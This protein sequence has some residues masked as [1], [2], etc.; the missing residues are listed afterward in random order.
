MLY[1][2]EDN[3]DYDA[4]LEPIVEKQVSDM[5]YRR[6]I[7]VAEPKHWT[8]TAASPRRLT[9]WLS[10]GSHDL[11]SKPL[12]DVLLEVMPEGIDFYPITVVQKGKEHPY[13]DMNVLTIA[14]VVD[15]DRSGIERLS[16]GHPIR[17]QSLHLKP[18]PESATPIFVANGDTLPFGLLCVTEPAA[19]NIAA[20]GFLDIAF[21]P[22]PVGQNIPERVL[23]TSKAINPFSDT[24][25]Q[26]PPQREISWPDPEIFTSPSLRLGPEMTDVQV[27]AIH[28]A[29]G[30]QLPDYYIQFLRNYPAILDTTPSDHRGKTPLSARDVPKDAGQLI[31]MNANVR[32]PGS[33][34]LEDEDGDL[35]WP[36]N[37]WVIGDASSD[38]YCI[39]TNSTEQ[40]V[41]VSD[42]E[43]A[44][45]VPWAASLEEFVSRLVE[46]ITAILEQVREERKSSAAF[47][48]SLRNSLD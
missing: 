28:E 2:L 3:A 27:Q 14:D 6:G 9:N 44:A 26:P 39:D 11:I 31:E 8:F 21:T 25:V 10:F 13:F 22:L 17:L 5:S 45:I 32:Q 38:Y 42:H 15:M 46:K 19:A 4:R 29:F 43:N 16:S 35:P 23:R 47:A 48:R 30:I 7:P 36:A 24:P 37:L 1:L 40:T 20:A 33:I 41:Y 18:L 34:W 12:R